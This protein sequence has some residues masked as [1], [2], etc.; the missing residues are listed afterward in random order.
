MQDVVMRLRN[1]EGERREGQEGG[2]RKSSKLNMN[3]DN[4][5]DF[6]TFLKRR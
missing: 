2:G 5:V 3:Y 4:L 6:F 1:R